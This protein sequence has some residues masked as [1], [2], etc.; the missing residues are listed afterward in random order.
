MVRTKFFAAAATLA[1]VAACGQQAQQA[2]TTPPPMA[3]AP[4]MNQASMSEAQFVQVAANLSA[5]EVEA[6]EL[7]AER[8]TAD[9]KAFAEQMQREHQTASQELTQLAP[10]LGMQAPAP[11]LDSEHQQDLAQLQSLNG[12]EFDDAYLDQ[13][14]ET[15]ENTVRTFEDYAQN[16]APGPLRDWAQAALPKLQQQLT[17][18]QSLENAS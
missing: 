2:E 12:A 16:G 10:T 13:Q 9:V 17:Q 6:A 8:A 5:F 1:L 11:A 14:V 4:V 3:E 7:A 18:A 15:H